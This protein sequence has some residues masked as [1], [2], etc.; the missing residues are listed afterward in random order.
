MH[1]NSKDI[2]RE[3]TQ[4]CCIILIKLAKSY[5]NVKQ[6]KGA[7]SLAPL[8]SVDSVWPG[9]LFP[10]ISCSWVVDGQSGWAFATIMSIY[11][12]LKVFHVDTTFLKD[13]HNLLYSVVCCSLMFLIIM[14]QSSEERAEMAI[15]PQTA[16]C[17]AFDEIFLVR[18]DPDWSNLGSCSAD[19]AW[20]GD[21]GPGWCG[22]LPRQ[23]PQHTKSAPPRFVPHQ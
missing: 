1:T 13:F 7:G 16:K 22:A 12:F 3:N 11:R 23:N 19:L 2:D 5:S 8:R 6:T 10:S 17:S 9:P 21:A 4:V 14:D 20:C 15:I 18:Y